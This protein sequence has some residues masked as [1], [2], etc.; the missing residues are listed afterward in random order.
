MRRQCK[1]KYTDSV[2]VVR[3]AVGMTVIFI[4]EIELHQGSAHSHGKDRIASLK[5]QLIFIVGIIALHQG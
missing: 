1:I 4:V 3:Y 2:I 5:N